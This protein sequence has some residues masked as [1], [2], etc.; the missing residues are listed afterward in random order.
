MYAAGGTCAERQPP[1]GVTD[2]DDLGAALALWDAGPE[3]ARLVGA[4]D[5]RVY[6]F[7]SGGRRRYLRLTPAD[8]RAGPAL[9]AELDYVRYLR[10]GGLAV[11]PPVPS[12]RGAHVE[13]V[14]GTAPGAGASVDAPVHATVFEEAPGEA[15]RY[16]PA[17]DNRPHFRQ[18]GRMLGRLH[19]LSRR[20]AR[21]APARAGGLPR[22]D[23]DRHLQEAAAYVPR[24]DEAFWAEFRALASWLGALPVDAEGFGPIHG[25]V[26]ATNY[27]VAGDALTLFDFGDACQ[28]WYAYDVAVS[29]YPYGD[30]P[31]RHALLAATLDGYAAEAPLGATWVEAL[32]HLCRLRVAYLYLVHA[33]RWGTASPA[34]EHAAWFARKRERMRCPIE[35]RL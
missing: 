12:R 24:E 22:W 11:A 32:G 10:E 35:W 20:Y 15:F 4:G 23:A 34:R 30:R 9:A 31:E 18:R 26:G 3:S 5:Q 7:T 25:D 27:R 2:M 1:H 14:G 29:V 6:A 19:V 33:R 13:P 8:V 28:H 17:A 16:D 21:V